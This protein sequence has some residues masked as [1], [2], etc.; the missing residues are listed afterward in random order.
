MPERRFEDKVTVDEILE[1]IP[2]QKILQAKIYIQ[3]VKTNGQ[4][5]T[6]VIEIGK[7]KDR[8]NQK[9][10]KEDVDRIEAKTDGKV[11]AKGFYIIGSILGAILTYIVIVGNLSGG[12]G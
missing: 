2:D 9:A 11:G 3:V 1:N 7:I 4:V 5:A 12:S 8:M 6:N 10:N